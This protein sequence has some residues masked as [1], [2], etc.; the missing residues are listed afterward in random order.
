MKQQP[1]QKAI[2]LLAELVAASSD[3]TNCNY[4][5]LAHS[6]IGRIQKRERDAVSAIFHALT[7]AY[8]SEAAFRKILP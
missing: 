4:R 2:E 8:P 7:G 3:V 6:T 1:T 5:T